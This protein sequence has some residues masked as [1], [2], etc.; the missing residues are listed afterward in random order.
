MTTP[1]SVAVN[2][3]RYR[4]QPRFFYKSDNP[5]VA[6]YW[7]ATLS[8][9]APDVAPKLPSGALLVDSRVGN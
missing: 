4:R 6:S 7:V 2:S 5:R 3:I 1:K 9:A 8:S